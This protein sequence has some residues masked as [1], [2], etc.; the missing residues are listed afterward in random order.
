MPVT[1][2]IPECQKILN[3]DLTS[4]HIIIC[5]VLLFGFSL[6]MLSLSQ[7]EQYYQVSVTFVFLLW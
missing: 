4:Y 2:K 7:P 6:F 1:C 5:G 3:C